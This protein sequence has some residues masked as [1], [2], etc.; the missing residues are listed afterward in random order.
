MVILTGSRN[1]ENNGGTMKIN[2]AEWILQ[3]Y[4]QG[5][6]TFPGTS[7]EKAKAVLAQ[8]PLVNYNCRECDIEWA[9][10]LHTALEKEKVCY[11]CSL[12]FI[13]SDKD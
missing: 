3:Q 13:A 6:Y 1:N 4:E 10:R 12:Y 8:H 2:D 9:E 5:A 11:R 7:I